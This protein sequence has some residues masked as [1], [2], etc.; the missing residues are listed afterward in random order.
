MVSRK[1]IDLTKVLNSL[2]VTC[3]ECGYSIPPNEQMRISMEQMRCPKTSMFITLA[4]KQRF[5]G[6]TLLVFPKAQAVKSV[7]RFIH[8]GFFLLL[9]SG[10]ITCAADS[11]NPSG[12][13][14]V[15]NT[16]WEMLR[17]SPWLNG[18]V[19]ATKGHTR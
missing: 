14:R 15:C 16:W 4:L 18:Q 12:R 2:N 19:L 17:S 6:R 11:S 8:L 5:A 9:A 13:S 10:G 1:K 7:K 3:P